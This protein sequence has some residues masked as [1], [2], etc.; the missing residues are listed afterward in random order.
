MLLQ[1]T[2]QEAVRAIH[3]DDAFTLDSLLRRRTISADTRLEVCYKTQKY[4]SHVWQFS[5]EIEVFVF[6]SHCCVQS[7]VLL[8]YHYKGGA[9]T[10]FV[11]LIHMFMH[12]QST[13]RISAIQHFIHS[14]AIEIC[15]GTIFDFCTVL[16]LV[17]YSNQVLSH[18]LATTLAIVEWNEYFLCGHNWF[19]LL[20]TWPVESHFV[21]LCGCMLL[22]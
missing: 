12:L 16:P 21:V 19:T 5:V 3:N 17:L 6:Q 10:R 1:V 8:N 9:H 4:T 14:D 7:A 20:L 11:D 22:F 15:D 18:F 13:Y 2:T